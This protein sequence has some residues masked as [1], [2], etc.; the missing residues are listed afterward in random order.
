MANENVQEPRRQVTDEIRRQ[1]H[2]SRAGSTYKAFLQ[3]LRSIG[4]FDEA[5][6]ERAA[7]TVLCL[8][9]RR[10]HSA[11]AEDLN[12][13]LP[14]KLRELIQR[15]GI[16]EGRPARKFGRDEFFRMVAE[17]LEKDVSEV[18]PIV[19]AVLTTV[20]AQ[21]SEGEAQQFGDMLPHDL[22]ELWRRP[23]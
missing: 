2:E 17:D 20:R 22:Q 8:L 16:H 4:G 15:C 21:V 23:S 19:R 12:A 13:Q 11:E 9:E 5:E 7:V 14:L 10:V 18:E 3:D 6:A 1:R